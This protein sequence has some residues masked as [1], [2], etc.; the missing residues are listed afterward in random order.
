M[1]LVSNYHDY[2]DGVLKLF[3]G[4]RPFYMRKESVLSISDAGLSK[5]T[6][7]FSSYSIN[8]HSEKWY[9][10]GCGVI[11]FCGELYPYAAF[12]TYGWSAVCAVDRIADL[13]VYRAEDVWAL[14]R[15]KKQTKKERRLDTAKRD[16]VSYF[17]EFKNNVWLKNLFLEHKVPVFDFKHIPSY[18]GRANLALNPSLAAR[19]FQKVLGPYQAMQNLDIFLSSVLV[20]ESTPLAQIIPDEVMQAKKGFT[21][22]YSFRKAPKNK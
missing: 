19:S 2:Y 4:K 11:G 1:K 15:S 6:D 12:S 13:Y 7:L 5:K 16:T 3:T 17:K 18:A 8:I 10:H 22:K 14:N 20:S 9:S 21:H